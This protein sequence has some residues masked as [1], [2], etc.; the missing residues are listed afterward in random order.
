[1]VDARWVV[2]WA[3]AVRLTAVGDDLWVVAKRWLT[4]GLAS[5]L[6][7]AVEVDLCVEVALWV[8]EGLIA[9]LLPAGEVDIRVLVARSSAGRVVD[10]LSVKVVADL[11]TVALFCPA[12]EFGLVL[13]AVTSV[14]LRSVPVP[15]AS[16]L[17]LC[18][19]CAEVLL[20]PV[21]VDV[22]ACVLVFRPEFVLA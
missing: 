6:L 9:V 18:A 21:P 13:Y 12:E 19:G 4:E 7:T 15:V 14:D 2:E 11:R 22:P 1:V 10:D 16:V 17:I 8:S 5:G 20:S 3:V